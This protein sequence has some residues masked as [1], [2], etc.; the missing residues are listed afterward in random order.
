MSHYRSLLVAV[1][2]LVLASPVAG[3]TQVIVKANHTWKDSGL[4][5]NAGDAV[6]ISAAGQ[7]SWN[8]EYNVGPGGDPID[9]FNAFDL[10]EPFDFFSQARLIAYIGNNPAQGHLGD[11][12]FFPQTSGYISIGSGQTFVAPYGGELWLIFNDGAVTQTTETNDNTGSVAANVTVGNSDPVGPAISIASPSGVYLQG[13]TATA[14]Y[15]CTDPGDTVATCNGP[16]ANSATVDTSATGHRAF[17]VVATDSH[18][19]TSSANSTYVVAD[20]TQAA[21][22]PTGMTFAPTFIGS[23]SAINIVTLINPQ[24]TTM[25]IGG[26][27]T[28]GPFQ[29]TANACKATLGPRHNCRIAVAYVPTFA[30]AER[31]ELDVAGGLAV[32]P[33]PLWGVGTQVRALPSSV[34]FADQ[35]VGSTSAPMTI[36]LQNGQSNYLAVEEIHAFGDF[37]IDPSSPCLAIAGKLR[38]H[39]TCAIV[40]TF[41]PTAQGAR[42][43]SVIVHTGTAMDPFAVSPS[44]NGVSE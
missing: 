26:V 29:I 28:Q 20:T 4:V 18:G 10:F 31:G 21:L 32:Q 43:G 23:R 3:A 30:G 17:T 25:T 19:N 8:G 14:S 24:A 44:G 1:F 34:A 9:D 40:V 7:W 16:V 36:T 6:T 38:V 2:A 39:K 22:F 37:A 27:T 41:T 11:P 33:V 5:L 42:T 12:S 15:A 13:D 35:A